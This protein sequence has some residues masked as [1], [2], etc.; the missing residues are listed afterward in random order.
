MKRDSED[1]PVPETAAVSRAVKTFVEGLE[2][3]GEWIRSV[4]V[5]EGVERRQHA[6]AIDPVHG[7]C[8]R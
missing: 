8:A 3:P 6:G 4:R 1:R 7:A 2:Q 5:R